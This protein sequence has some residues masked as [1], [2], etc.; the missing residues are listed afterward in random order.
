LVERRLWAFGAGFGFGASTLTAII[1][2][3][4]GAAAVLASEVCIRELECF[5]CPF[6]WWDLA[7]LLCFF[8]A[9]SK[10]I[11]IVKILLILYFNWSK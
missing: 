6:L 8:E 7:F 1:S 11:E 10:K 5:W 9:Y 2:F 3:L 4:A